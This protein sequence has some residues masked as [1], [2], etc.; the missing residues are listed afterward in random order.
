MA[1]RSGFLAGRRVAVFAFSRQ[2]METARRACRAL[3]DAGERRLYAPARL[4]EGDF[5]PITGSLADFVGPLFQ[6]ADALLF[7]SSC[8][9]AVRAVAPHLRHKAADPAVLAVDERARFVVPLLS[10]HIGG[11]NR[12]ARILADAL[13]GTAVVTTATDVS[14]KF[15]VDAWAAEQGLHIDSMEDAKAVSAAILEGPV[16]LASDFPVVGELPSGV[17]WTADPP[18]A[19]GERPAVGFCVSWRR[20]EIF[21]RTLLLIP[22]AVRLGIGCRRGT[23]R[24]DIRAAVDRALEE[25]GIQ[26]AAVR[27]AASIDLKRDEPGLLAYCEGAGLPLA[28]YS[29]GEL[30]AVEGDFTPSEFVRSVTGVDNVCERAALLGA[31][32][33][34]MRKFAQN[35]VTVAAA[36]EHWEVRFG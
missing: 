11:A 12:L 13:G 25:S 8:G 1:D 9:I 4:A 27:C 20:R 22:K 23:G 14:G 36:A 17:V 5:Q 16:G 3:D 6:W 10:G 24:E 19:R 30:A 35:G 32:R 21:G 28:F 18:A 7:V 26:R 31:E 2:G 29:A 15:S 33:L 34:I